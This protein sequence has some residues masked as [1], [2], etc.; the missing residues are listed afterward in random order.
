MQ[1][2]PI[3]SVGYAPAARA[4]EGGISPS[5]CTPCVLGKRIC[6]LPFSPSVEDCGGGQ[7]FCTDVTPCIPFLNQK[8]QCCVPGECSLVPC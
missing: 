3:A 6:G 1:T 8:V 5:F 7:V 2:A 4:D